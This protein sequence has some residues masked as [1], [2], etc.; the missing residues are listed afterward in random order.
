MPYDV[1]VVGAGMVGAALVALLRESRSTP[2]PPSR[3]GGRRAVCGRARHTCD[4]ARH[5]RCMPA[6]RHATRTDRHDRACC[7]GGALA[8]VQAPTR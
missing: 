5:V 2:A 1:A 7:D 3:A 4:A 8:A 6:A